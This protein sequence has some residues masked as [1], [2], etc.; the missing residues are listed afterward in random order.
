MQ[1]HT[2]RKDAVQT[3][4]QTGSYFTHADHISVLSH[5][6]VFVSVY[7][8][9]LSAEVWFLN[10]E[11]STWTTGHAPSLACWACCQDQGSAHGTSEM[12]IFCAVRVAADRKV[13]I[14]T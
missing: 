13:Q 1:K 8:A 11:Y 3:F 12:A 5:V 2:L 6:P 7:V 4:A 10:E 14:K 9:T